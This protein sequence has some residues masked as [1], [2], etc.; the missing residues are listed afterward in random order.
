MKNV[1]WR[2]IIIY[3]FFGYGISWGFALL[4]HFLGIEL[5]GFFSTIIIAVFYMS[6]PAFSTIIVQKLIYKEKLNRLGLG[7]YKKD[8][9]NFI[10]IPLIVIFLIFLTTFFIYLFGNLHLINGFGEIVFSNKQIISHLQE[11][12]KEK[13]KDVDLTKTIIGKIPG[14]FFFIASLIQGIV[15][16]GI[17]NIPFVFGEEFG[18]RGFLFEETKKMGF[19][20]SSIL[21]GLVWGIWHFPIILMGLNYPKHP[22]IGSL[23]MIFFTLSLSPIFSFIRIKTNTIWGTCLL[24]A[25]ING[26]AGIFG[27]FVFKNNEIYSSLSGLAGILAATI[28]GIIIFFR[29]KKEITNFYNCE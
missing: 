23:L 14:I 8:L 3:I 22:Y 24:H 19:I 21:I 5:G 10:Y 9:I 29:N 4:M 18:W 25:M 26:T 1:Y 12:L 15:I 2:K 6:G 11:L 27:I 16:G 17:F 20:K 7:I 28:I 13:G